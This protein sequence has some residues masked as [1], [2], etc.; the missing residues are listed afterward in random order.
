MTRVRGYSRVCFVT[1]PGHPFL[2]HPDFA[3][4]ASEGR[5]PGG[6]SSLVLERV[7]S[8][9][10]MQEG[11]GALTVQTHVNRGHQSLP[12]N[13]GCVACEIA[14]TWLDQGRQ[15]RCRQCLLNAYTSCMVDAWGNKMC[16]RC[17]AQLHHINSQ[18]RAQSG[19]HE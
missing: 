15:E 13:G 9:N 11:S 19:T 4:P 18:R 12:M 6:D 16:R 5:D 1:M 10:T 8:P 7:M 3:P 17:A 14:F 2:Q